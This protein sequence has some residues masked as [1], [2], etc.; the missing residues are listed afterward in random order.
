M[1]FLVALGL[2]NQTSFHYLERE[3]EVTDNLLMKTVMLGAFVTALGIIMILGPGLI[4]ISGFDGAFSTFFIGIIVA[5]LG[6]IIAAIYLQ[7]ANIL[8][9]ILRGEGRLAHWTF[10]PERGKSTQSMLR[11]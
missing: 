10:E 7:Q 1:H 11:R 6:V 4:G 8:N 9:G 3:S 2:K 5:I